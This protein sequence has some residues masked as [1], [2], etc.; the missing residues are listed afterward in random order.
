MG[1]VLTLIPFNL[2]QPLKILKNFN[3][4]VITV[5]HFRSKIS[6]MSLLISWK[7]DR[8]EIDMIQEFGSDW[9]NI[10]LSDLVKYISGKTKVPMDG[11]KLL[12]SGGTKWEGSFGSLIY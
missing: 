11:I 6:E 1:Q 5:K 9:V 10:P 12:S 2:T 8:Y 4:W 3:A 7:S